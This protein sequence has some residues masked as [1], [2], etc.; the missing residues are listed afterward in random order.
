MISNNFR[1]PTAVAIG[2]AVESVIG[3]ETSPISQLV[4]ALALLIGAV[5]MLVMKFV[6][7]K[8]RKKEGG[9]GTGGLMEAILDVSERLGVI[10]EK[11]D[12]SQQDIAILNTWRDELPARIRDDV[13][14]QL[15]A[16]E[17][18]VNRLE[19]RLDNL[20]SAAPPK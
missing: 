8:E 3:S 7:M 19:D 15:N 20:P 16:Y 4:V 10:K 6:E 1:L 12:R 18:Q 2:W 9:N 17:R 14:R 13:Q 5:G 11:S